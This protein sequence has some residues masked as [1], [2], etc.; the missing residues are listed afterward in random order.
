MHSTD[1]QP[2]GARSVSSNQLVRLGTV[3]TQTVDRKVFIVDRRVLFD[4][5]FNTQPC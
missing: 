1:F 5:D 4:P 2:V 3:D